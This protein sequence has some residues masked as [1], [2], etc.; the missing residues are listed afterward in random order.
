MS[1]DLAEFAADLRKRG[2]PRDLRKAMKTALVGV[3]AKAKRESKLLATTRLSVRTGKLRQSIYSG[4]RIKRD[5]VEAFTGSKVPYAAIQERGGVVRPRTARMLAIPLGAAK[6]KAGVNRQRPR[7]YTDLFI[8]KSKSGKLLL[9]RKNGDGIEPLFLLVHQS[10]I[11]PHWYLRD[12]MRSAAKTADP[13]LRKVLVQ[14]VEES[15]NG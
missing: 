10:K 2:D 15:P 6:T 7:D 4:T 5:T 9:V 13:L 14:T 8:I 12:G 3:A 11:R 1:R